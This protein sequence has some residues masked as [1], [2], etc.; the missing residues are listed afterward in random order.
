MFK[1]LQ[2]GD[3]TVEKF[4]VSRKIRI[5][6]DS[7]LPENRIDVLDGIFQRP[8]FRAEQYE[9]AAERNGEDG[10]YKKMVFD[11]VRHLYYNN[12]TDY[13]RF[14]VENHRDII[15]DH[16]DEDTD[17]IL[18]VKVA[19]STY[20]EKIKPGSVRFSFDTG[21][22]GSVAETREVFDDGDGNLFAENGV[23]VGNVFYS[24]GAIVFTKQ[25]ASAGQ[26]A[27]YTYFPDY[28]FFE[29]EE[30]GID[31]QGFEQFELEFENQL[32]Y[33][34][35]EIKCEVLQHEFNQTTNR[36]LEGENGELI[37]YAKSD[38]FRPYITTV[39]LYDDFLNLVAVGKL[40]NPVKKPEA[41][42]LTITVK[43][44][45]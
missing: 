7:Q 20:G 33:F 24:N 25:A 31:F 44:D 38:D 12:G 41:M 35:H 22:S 23:I 21:E 45:T 29:P 10:P 30:G 17:Q 39:G 9:Q 3:Y 43:F 4:R 2:P 5:D 8:P 26:S 11:L 13:D 42:P 36:T 19:P 32:T 28:A 1:N 18:V 40:A 16:F 34:E 6:Y 37:E 27:I 14:G 15:L